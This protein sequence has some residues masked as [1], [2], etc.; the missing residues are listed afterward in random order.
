MQ[1]YSRLTTTATRSYQ[2]LRRGFAAQTTHRV[3]DPEVYSQREHEVQPANPSGDPEET[4]QKYEPDTTKRETGTEPGIEP[5]YTS[6]PK[7]PHG[8]SP[9]LEH[10][11]VNNPAEPFV[12]QRRKN[13]T[14]EKLKD[15]SCAGLDGWPKEG[16]GSSR[17]Q[18]RDNESDKDYF[19]HHKASPLS[20]IKIADTR[21]PISRATDQQVKGNET[22]IGWRPEQLDT[23]EESLQ[24]A[25]RIYK[26]NAMRGDP[27]S[28]H[29]RVLRT[30]RGEWF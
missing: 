25:T 7:S 9:R 4:K 22:V 15:V 16:K 14:L 24:R 3:A 21:K 28:P 29:G 6:S 5:G 23:A 11:S 1:R 27:D 19:K 13:S 20:E 2:V 17:D 10:V 8:A 12:Q 18:G 30:L 26:E